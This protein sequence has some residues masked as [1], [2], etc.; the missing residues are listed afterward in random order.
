MG[1]R[2]QRNAVDVVIAVVYEIDM[3]KRQKRAVSALFMDIKEAFNNVS[4]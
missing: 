1:G 2:C 3:G 4:K